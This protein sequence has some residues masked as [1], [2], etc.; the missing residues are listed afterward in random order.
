VTVAKVT[1]P[2]SVTRFPA[3]VREC[4]CDKAIGASCG[5]K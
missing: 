3:S 1:D 4:G 2:S 5:S